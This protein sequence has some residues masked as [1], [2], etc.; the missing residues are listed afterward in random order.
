MRKFS[1][2][3]IVRL[4]LATSLT[5][6]VAGA[7]CI[8]GCEGMIASAAS[9]GSA[10]S[11]HHPDKSPIVVASGDACSAGETNKSHDCCKKSAGKVKPAA[12][13]RNSDVS[14]LELN[15]SSSGMMNGCPLA[16]SRTAVVAK[17]RGD[18]FHSTPVL[19]QSVLPDSNSAERTAPLSSPLRLPNRGHTYLR[20]CVFLI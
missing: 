5:L 15:G 7:G 2:V 13:A 20:C 8:L 3:K 17:I 12:P 6:W 16:M 19:V 10:E 4:L 11:T 9:G 14:L 1:P 18:D